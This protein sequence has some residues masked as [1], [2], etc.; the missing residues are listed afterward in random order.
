MKSCSV[1][2]AGC[3]AFAEGA[4]DEA[5]PLVWVARR[6]QACRPV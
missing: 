3:A 5:G 2:S 4:G 6:F 1:T